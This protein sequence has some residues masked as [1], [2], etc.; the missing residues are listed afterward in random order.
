MIGRALLMLL[1][2]PVIIGCA[3]HY[4][5]VSNDTLQLYLR[6]S[7]AESVLFACSLEGFKPRP[8]DQIDSQLWMVSTKADETFRYFY[9][10]DGN[11]FTPPCR[12]KENDDFGHEDCIYVPG[13]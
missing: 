7:Q 12:F 8:A 6:Q 3:S 1:P 11:V 2:L 4:T 5:K 13:L 9:I 10:V